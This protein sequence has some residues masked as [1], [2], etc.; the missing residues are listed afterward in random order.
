MNEAVAKP[1]VCAFNNRFI[2]RIGGFLPSGQPS[3]NI[4][5]YDIILNKWY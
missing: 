1:S 3:K 2:F 5:K 4:E